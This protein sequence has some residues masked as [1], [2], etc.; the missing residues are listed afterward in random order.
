[1][2]EMLNSLNAKFIRTISILAVLFVAILY[3]LFISQSYTLLSNEWLFRMLVLCE[4]LLI[5]FMSSYIYKII[6]GDSMS[7]IFQEIIDNGMSGS[8]PILNTISDG[9]I[10]VDKKGVIKDINQGLCSILGIH[11]NEI[12]GSNITSLNKNWCSNHENKLFLNILAETLET[13]TEFT[14]VECEYTKDDEKLYIS[15]STH[16]LCNKYKRI[17]G[18]MAVLHDFTYE[19]KLEQ[20][21]LRTEKLANAGQMAAELAHEIK[22]PICSI[23]GLLQIMGKKQCLEENKYYEVITSE[24]ERISV[25]LQ[26]F[27]SLTQDVPKL[28]RVVLNKLVEEVVPLL[29]SYAEYKSIDI[30]V[31]MQK[32]IPCVYADAENIKQVIIN[33]VQNG[34][35]ALP[36]DGRINISIWYDQIRDIMRMEFKDNGSGIKPEYLDKIF[37]PFFTTKDNGSGLGLAISHKIIENHRGRL[38][39]FNN[40]EGGATFV[41]E[42]PV[43]KQ[44]FVD[45]IRIS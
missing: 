11:E 33:I 22:N 15:I 35:D 36:E 18:V 21:L 10:M 17:I 23:R 14:Q 13:K 39:A 16:L 1:M 3:A 34:I 24:I 26:R 38:F 12:L 42:L 45:D 27:L 40:L 32:Q 29:E 44:Y 41:I 4:M 20:Y 7:D 25:L 6:R 5:V 43:D 37:E 28:G 9:I 19:K 30:S 2:K 8:S 31:D